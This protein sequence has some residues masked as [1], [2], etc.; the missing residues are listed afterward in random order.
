MR[1]RLVAQELSGSLLA[2]R[3]L[4]GSIRYMLSATADNY[5]ADY[6]FVDMSPSLGPINQKTPAKKAAKSKKSSSMIKS[7]QISPWLHHPI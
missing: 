5:N 1:R 6:I 3:N 2:L 4:P 7:C